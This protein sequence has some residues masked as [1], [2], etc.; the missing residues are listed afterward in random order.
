MNNMAEIDE[1]LQGVVD[2]NE[3]PGLVMVLSVSL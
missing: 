3:I 2:R 1:L